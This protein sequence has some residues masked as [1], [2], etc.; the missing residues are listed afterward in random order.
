VQGIRLEKSK[1][2]VSDEVRI[3]EVRMFGPSEHRE[4][5]GQGRKKDLDR[6]RERIVLKARV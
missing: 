3:K 4:R 1:E 5:I 6:R 2:E